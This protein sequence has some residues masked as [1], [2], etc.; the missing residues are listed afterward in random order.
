[1]N[2]ESSFSVDNNNNNLFTNKKLQLFTTSKLNSIN[3]S[4][5]K[6]KRIQ[7]LLNNSASNETS[8]HTNDKNYL[9]E[10]KLNQSILNKYMEENIK[11]DSLS[12]LQANINR[13]QEVDQFEKKQ[14]VFAI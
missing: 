8:P 14:N 3:Q 13:N 1:M 12:K 9:P 7:S 5:N 10:I 4:I 11:Q 2:I 6:N